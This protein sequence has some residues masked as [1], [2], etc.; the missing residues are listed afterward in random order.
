MPTQ[1]LCWPIRFISNFCLLSACKCSPPSCWAASF[2]SYLVAAWA[3]TATH[4]IF[5]SV[6]SFKLSLGGLECSFTSRYLSLLV[7]YSPVKLVLMQTQRFLLFL[8]IN[9]A[10]PANQRD[11]LILNES[12]SYLLPACL[13]SGFRLVCASSGL[14]PTTS[15]LYQN[16]HAAREDLVCGSQSWQVS[17]ELYERYWFWALIRELSISL[18]AVASQLWLCSFPLPPPEITVSVWVSFYVALDHIFGAVPHHKL[19]MPGCRNPTIS[20]C[21]RRLTGSSTVCILFH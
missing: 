9:I 13:H 18:V 1:S 4:D 20:W 2:C 17:S 21:F 5:V 19:L 8:H 10:P 7:T 12:W 16:R 6:L 14:S 3:T 15:S 11:T